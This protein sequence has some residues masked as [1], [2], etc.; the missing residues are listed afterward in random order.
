MIPRAIVKTC[1]HE[2]F[3]TY[4]IIRADDTCDVCRREGCT[5][6]ELRCTGV[7]TSGDCG[8]SA[9]A[10]QMIR[11]HIPKCWPRLICN[12]RELRKSDVQDALAH[13][14]HFEVHIVVC[15]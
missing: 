8:W 15:Q 14:F 11:Q 7:D 6:T 9:S 1:M 4:G 2:G 5:C 10:G 12:F 3:G 13:D